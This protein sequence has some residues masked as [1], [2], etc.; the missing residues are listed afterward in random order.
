MRGAVLQ[1]TTAERLVVDS[2]A[3]GFGLRVNPTCEPIFTSIYEL[4]IESIIESKQ[5]Q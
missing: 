1:T 3:S 4:T 5:S 2:R